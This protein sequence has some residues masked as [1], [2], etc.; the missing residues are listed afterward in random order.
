MPEVL[1][2]SVSKKFVHRPVLFGLLGERRGSTQALRDVSVAVG[3]G[4]VL[5]LLGANGAGKSTLLK[6]ICTM[7]LPEHGRVTVSGFDAAR[8]GM[9]VRH[10]VGFALAHER[11]FYP[12]LTARENLNFF[13]ALEDVPRN[14]RPP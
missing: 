14:R 11:S 8:Q 9:E 3:R 6:L 2:E 5:A 12:R 4:E 1:L 13:A 7:L 10:R